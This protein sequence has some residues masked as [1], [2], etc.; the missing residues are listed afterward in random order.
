MQHSDDVDTLLVSEASTTHVYSTFFSAGCVD[1][2]STRTIHLGRDRVTPFNDHKLN[3]D[4]EVADALGNKTL[5]EITSLND[6]RNR[7][8]AVGQLAK[9]CVGF[10]Y[11]SVR[12]AQT[13]R[14]IFWIN[15][16]VKHLLGTLAC[17][18]GHSLISSNFGDIHSRMLSFAVVCS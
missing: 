12:G 8:R 17:S 3:A 16:I 2:Q 10:A 9:T 14:Q 5:E 4:Q 15:L 11:L 13:L 1:K 6:V 18:L 7:L